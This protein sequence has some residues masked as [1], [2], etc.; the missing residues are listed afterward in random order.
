MFA[1]QARLVP[2]RAATA[3]LRHLV[4]PSLTLGVL[5]AGWYARMMRSS[6]IDVLRQDYIR[7][8]RAKGLARARDPVPPCAAQRASCRSSP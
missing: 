1:V 6:M 5:G 7:T 2:D 4:L 3:R 8:A